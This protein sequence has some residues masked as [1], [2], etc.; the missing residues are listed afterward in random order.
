MIALLCLHAIKV[1]CVMF[2][3]LF[4][5]NQYDL[6]YSVCVS[7][8]IYILCT[9]LL[10]FIGLVLFIPNSYINLESK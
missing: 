2:I 5:K 9:D 4:L 8:Y 3:L 7:I 1:M 6:I 10:I